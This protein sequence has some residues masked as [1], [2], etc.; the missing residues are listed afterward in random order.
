MLGIH[1]T[2]HMNIKP[3]V[4]PAIRADKLLLCSTGSLLGAFCSLLPIFP[5]YGITAAPHSIALQ[6]ERQHVITITGLPPQTVL[7]MAH[8]SHTS[9]SSTKKLLS[10]AATIPIEISFQDRHRLQGRHTAAAD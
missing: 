2:A 1:E 5:S 10:I 8:Q 6:S 3:K 7:F 9:I 4:E